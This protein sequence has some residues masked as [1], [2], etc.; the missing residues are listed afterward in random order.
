MPSILVWK[1]SFHKLNVKTQTQKNDSAE[2]KL[3][4]EH[5]VENKRNKI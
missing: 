2:R 1:M 5:N 4:N 3:K